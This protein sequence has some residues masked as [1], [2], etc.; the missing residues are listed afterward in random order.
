MKIG[1]CLINV[2]NDTIDPSKL[3]VYRSFHPDKLKFQK[4]YFPKRSNC[5]ENRIGHKNYKKH[6]LE[7]SFNFRQFQIRIEKKKCEN[8]SFN[9]FEK[10]LALVK[11][12]WIVIIIQMFLGVNH[13]NV[14]F[15]SIFPF[16]F[17]FETSLPIYYYEEIKSWNYHRIIARTMKHIDLFS[18]I[19][20]VWIVSALLTGL[21]TTCKIITLHLRATGSRI[22]SRGT[23]RGPD[24]C[25]NTLQ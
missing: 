13:K 8:Q 18:K 11:H 9:C 4:Y 21:A 7:N 22:L 14:Y 23:K 5:I 3:R 16:F 6:N 15:T 24:V 10:S 19:L 12:L 17:F 20:S 2:C 1:F 25:R